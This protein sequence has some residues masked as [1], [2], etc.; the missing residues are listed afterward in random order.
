MLFVS[1]SFLMLTNTGYENLASLRCKNIIQ[2]MVFTV[3]VACEAKLVIL[4]KPKHTL[5]MFKKVDVSMIVNHKQLSSPLQ[6]VWLML[7]HEGAHLEEEQ[8]CVQVL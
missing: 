4:H 1:A 5:C 8:V 2:T 6:L 7:S 3:T